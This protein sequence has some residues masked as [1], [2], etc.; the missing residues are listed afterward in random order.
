MTNVK[1]VII[2]RGQEW[3]A[4]VKCQLGR[5]SPSPFLRQ[6]YLGRALTGRAGYVHE[7]K[8]RPVLSFG[9]SLGNRG[10]ARVRS[11]ARIKAS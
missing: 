11:E 2:N 7:L 9:P 5:A 8:L 3:G 4:R 6:F 10:S 1:E